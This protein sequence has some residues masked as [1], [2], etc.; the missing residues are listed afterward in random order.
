MH[1]RRWTL[2]SNCQKPKTTP[3]LICDSTDKHCTSMCLLE[4]FVQLHLHLYRL[5]DNAPSS[6]KLGLTYVGVIV[7]EYLFCNLSHA[8]SVPASSQ[9]VGARAATALYRPTH[10]VGLAIAHARAAMFEHTC[11]YARER[12]ICCL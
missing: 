12:G 5:R 3:I 4:V 7:L 9:D 2:S 11:V 8:L 10:L 6:D 1:V